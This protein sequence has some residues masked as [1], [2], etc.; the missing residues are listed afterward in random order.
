MFSVDVSW[1]FLLRQ[2][3]IPRVKELEVETIANN[4]RD[5]AGLAGQT[6]NMRIG[7]KGADDTEKSENLKMSFPIFDE[8]LYIMNEKN[9]YESR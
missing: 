2:S 8:N 6:E 3:G 4:V 9:H 1:C 7:R 5:K